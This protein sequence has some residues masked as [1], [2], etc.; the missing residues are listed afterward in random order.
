MERVLHPA[1]QG[2]SRNGGM[3]LS[4][5]HQWHEIAPLVADVFEVLIFLLIFAM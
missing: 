1:F 2:G 4:S 3:E 5:G